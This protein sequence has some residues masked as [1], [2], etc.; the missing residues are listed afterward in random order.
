LIP[1]AENTLGHIAYAII[2]LTLLI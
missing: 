1:I 2:R